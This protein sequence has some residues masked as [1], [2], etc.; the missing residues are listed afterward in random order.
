MQNPE[1]GLLAHVAIDVDRL[2]KEWQDQPKRHLAAALR[3]AKALFDLNKKKFNL[4]TVEARLA[5]GFRTGGIPGLDKVT[6]RALEEAVALH[7]DYQAARQELAEAEHAVA[8]LRGVCDA[9]SQRVWALKQ[10]SET[11]GLRDAAGAAV[12]QDRLMSTA[13]RALG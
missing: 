2:E 7:P 8:V 11:P 1:D 10:L 9:L 5:S 13:R 12:E 3:H 4:E 6:E